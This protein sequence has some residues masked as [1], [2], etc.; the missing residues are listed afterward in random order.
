MA[1]KQPDKQ[2]EEKAKNGHWIGW[3]IWIGIA[4][5]F[6][7]AFIDWVQEE[8]KEREKERWELLRELRDEEARIKHEIFTQRP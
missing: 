6:V 8:K 4:V 2:Q 3:L 1:S 7:G 5:L